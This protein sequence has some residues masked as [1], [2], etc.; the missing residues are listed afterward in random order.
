MEPREVRQSQHEGTERTRAEEIHLAPLL[1]PEPPRCHL[2]GP[3]RCHLPAPG[4]GRTRGQPRGPWARAPVTAAVSAWQESV[5]ALTESWDRLAGEA[6]KL[7]DNCRNTGTWREQG[8]MALRLL[9]HLVS[10][11]DRATVFPWELLRQLGDIEATLV[12]TREA[13]P[14][15][16][17]ALVAAVAET[18]RLWEASTCLTPSHLLGALGDI[19]T[20]LGSL[21]DN[22]QWPQ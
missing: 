9:G 4:P 15:V 11:C 20:L 8:Q 7:R 12:E 21:C 13:S 17:K 1:H 6:T 10:L 5:A 3:A 18:E 2:P 16:P 22:P 19:H 14:S